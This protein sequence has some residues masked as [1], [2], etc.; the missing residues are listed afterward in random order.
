MPTSQLDRT[1]RAILDVLQHNGRISNVDLAEKVHLSP[2]PCLRRV[3]ALEAS[4]II[5][6]Y[7]ALLEPSGVGLGLLA[8]VSVKLEKRGKMPSQEFAKAVQGWSEVVACYSLTGDM[9][10]LLRVN[11]RDL[12]DYSRFMMNRLLKYAGVIDTRSSIVLER[13]KET[14]AVP[15]NTTR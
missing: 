6:Q 13:I 14:T 2:S 3:Q 1:D 7:V 5:R 4:G 9:D 12:D 15:L 11:V 10:Y 8:F